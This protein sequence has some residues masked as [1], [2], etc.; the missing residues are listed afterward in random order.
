MVSRNSDYNMI[1]KDLFNLRQ[2]KKK[3]EE[4]CVQFVELQLLLIMIYFLQLVKWPNL[5]AQ[6][7]VP[8]F[9]RSCG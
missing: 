9:P 8:R 7:R 6:F 5:N 1:S 4:M 2:C 3:D